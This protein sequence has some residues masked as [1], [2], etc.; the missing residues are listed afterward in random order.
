MTLAVETTA[1]PRLA[2]GDNSA[3]VPLDEILA[4]E[5]LADA[6][7]RDEL[8]TAANA[9]AIT[10]RETQKQVAT[11]AGLIGTHWTEVE[12]KRKARKTP[13]DQAAISV[14][15]AY[16]P[17]LAPLVDARNRLRTLN[18]DYEEEQLRIRQ[19]ERRRLEEEEERQRKIAEE[20]AKKAEE[21][22]AKGK[23]GL[24]D[25]LAAIRARDDAA[26]AARAAEAAAQRPAPIRTDV[27]SASRSTV[28]TYEVDD[29]TMTLG[30]LRRTQRA[31]LIEAIQPLVNKIARAGIKVPGVK[32]E[33]RQQTR[34]SR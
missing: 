16:V 28:T 18:D 21:A 29:L 13:F 26:A 22:V 3:A 32:V 4:D 7:R 15:K 20:A 24:A 23:S 33:Q 27:G 34:F 11:L 8:V 12:A 19:A 9:A 17:V 6:K 25:E 5:V 14:Q 30:Y 31:A 10:D 2:P 1:D